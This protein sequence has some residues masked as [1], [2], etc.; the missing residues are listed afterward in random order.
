VMRLRRV[1]GFAVVFLLLGAV[2]FG[3][4]NRRTVLLTGAD[5]PFVEVIANCGDFDVMN[6]YSFTYRTLVRTNAAGDPV[7]VVDHFFLFDSVYYNSTDPSL[8]APGEVEHVTRRWDLVDGYLSM[9]GPGVRVRVPG[10]QIVFRH[11]GHWIFDTTT[12][13]WTVIFQKGKSDVFEGNIDAL[14]RA[15]RPE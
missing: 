7:A 1:F 5:G 15:L 13:P 2:S 11:T 14:C 12:D 3:Q 4:G 8:Y 10:G 9:S 6:S